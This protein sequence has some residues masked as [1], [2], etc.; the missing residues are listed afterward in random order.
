MTTP[1][2]IY[3]RLSASQRPRYALSVARLALGQLQDAKWSALAEQAIACCEAWCNGQP[4]K[5]E[6]V[7]DLIHD[8]S[9]H[10]LDLLAQEAHAHQLPVAPAVD[11]IVYAV[12]Y[13]GWRINLLAPPVFELFDNA[14]EEMLGEMEAFACSCQ[15]I[16]RVQ[17]EAI[18]DGMRLCLAPPPGGLACGQPLTSQ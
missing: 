12:A 2:D 10:G 11:T 4:V 18:A 15:G 9:D 16:D 8:E 17:L 1:P 6:V 3:K 14:S 13:V 5:H 7:V